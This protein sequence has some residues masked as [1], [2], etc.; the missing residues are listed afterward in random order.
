MEDK[1]TKRIKD[2]AQAKKPRFAS[3]YFIKNELRNLN[4]KEYN[5]VIEKLSSIHL[6]LQGNAS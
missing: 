4:C 5:N 2:I 1:N 3:Y 6:M